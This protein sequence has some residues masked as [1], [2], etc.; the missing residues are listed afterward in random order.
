MVCAKEGCF[1]LFYFMSFKVPFLPLNIPRSFVEPMLKLSRPLYFDSVMAQDG[2]AVE[3]EQDGWD[4]HWDMPMMELNPAVRAMQDLAIRKWEDYLANEGARQQRRSSTAP[5]DSGGKSSIPYPVQT[6]RSRK[7]PICTRP[8]PQR[9]STASRSTGPLSMA[10]RHDAGC[11][12]RATHFR[13]SASG[14][15]PTMS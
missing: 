8:W 3:A 9:G 2:F 7:S 15:S 14:S 13:G 4:N 1:F 5:Q 6:R 12:C 11:R 10:R